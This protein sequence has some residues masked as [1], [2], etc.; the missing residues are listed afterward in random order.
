MSFARLGHV[1]LVASHLAGP[2]PYVI[3]ATGGGPL[4]RR[5]HSF[6][7]PGKDLIQRDPILLMSLSMADVSFQ[8]VGKAGLS[9]MA[10]QYFILWRG[11]DSRTKLPMISCADVVSAI[12]GCL[13]QGNVANKLILL[14][15]VPLAS[16]QP[17]LLPDIDL[18]F[19]V[20]NTSLDVILYKDVAMALSK[21]LPMI[22]GISMCARSVTNGRAMPYEVIRGAYVA[23]AVAHPSLQAPLEIS[24]LDVPMH[25]GSISHSTAALDVVLDGQLGRCQHVHASWCRTPYWQE[26]LLLRS[27]DYGLLR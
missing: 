17:A 14:F 16:S 21:W 18:A 19:I 15:E 24:I 11:V 7:R 4:V 23:P 9:R 6:V 12:A 5:L 2:W 8:A 10:M 26:L 3:S 20:T 13:I 27:A 25:S 22:L 1:V